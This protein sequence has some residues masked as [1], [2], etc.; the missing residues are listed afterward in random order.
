MCVNEHTF[1][2]YETGL[3]CEMSSCWNVE[4]KLNKWK[5]LLEASEHHLSM[6]RGNL[7]ART[8]Q[9]REMKSERT[10][11]SYRSAGREYAM[12]SLYSPRH[13]IT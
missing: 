9:L 3:R 12:S 5:P 13:L 4:M 7:Y 2:H 6:P 10:S 8:K 1:Y 11:H